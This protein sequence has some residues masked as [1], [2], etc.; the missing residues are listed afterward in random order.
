MP[1]T[2]VYGGFK[3]YGEGPYPIRVL[4]EDWLAAIARWQGR[5]AEGIPLERPCDS[6]G[7]I[8]RIWVNEPETVSKAR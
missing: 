3:N 4:E 5:I 8:G 6:N 7:W 2:F 1:T